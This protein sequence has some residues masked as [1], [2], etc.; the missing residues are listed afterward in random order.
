MDPLMT[1][2]VFLIGIII[3]V[4]F[5][6]TL[7]Y[8]VAISPL[9]KK[10]EK[11]TSEKESLSTAWDKITEQYASSTEKYPYSIENFRF[12]GS[13]IDGVQFEDDQILFVEF[14]TDKSKLNAKQ[15]KIKKLVKEGKVK[16]FEFK[17][18]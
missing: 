5:G 6:I 9:H 17:T 11:F 10:V 14:K 12:I 3:G 2:W 7:V 1:F 8:K 4:I 18:K 13:P 16:W 15:N